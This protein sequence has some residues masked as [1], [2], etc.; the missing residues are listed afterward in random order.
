MAKQVLDCSWSCPGNLSVMSKK[1]QITL[2]AKKH[3]VK[4]DG[5]GGGGGG[6]IEIYGKY[7]I[8]ES[9]KTHPLVHGDDLVI[10]LDLF[11]VR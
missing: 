7:L 9:I 10:I 3:F 5:H 11:T 4:E 1:E 8:A 2:G 6:N